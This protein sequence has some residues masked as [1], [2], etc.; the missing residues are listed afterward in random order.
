M[1]FLIEADIP[2]V[3]LCDVVLSNDQDR[4]G[5]AVEDFLSDAS[6]DK[7]GLAL[8]T[9]GPHNYKVLLGRFPDD[10]VRRIT[11]G[12]MSMCLVAPGCRDL[13]R[14]RA[15]LCRDGIDKVLSPPH[16]ILMQILMKA[17]MIGQ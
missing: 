5:D 8:K 15:E 6:I 10:D 7:S 17:I 12:N 9:I 3:L 4:D 1:A 2:P 16:R 14:R 11:T 13:G